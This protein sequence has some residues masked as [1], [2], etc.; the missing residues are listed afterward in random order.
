MSMNYAVI[1]SLSL[2]PHMNNHP[3]I[4]PKIK[5]E[6]CLDTLLFFIIL[7]IQIWEF[8]TCWSEEW[9]LLGKWTVIA[10]FW[11]MKAEGIA[12]GSRVKFYWMKLPHTLTLCI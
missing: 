9:S 4:D 6:G 8:K 3:L 2:E 11:S 7:F 1:K 10:K 12:L 5:L